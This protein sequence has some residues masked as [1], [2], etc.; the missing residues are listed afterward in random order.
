MKQKTVCLDFN[1]VVHS[2]TTPW[3]DIYTIADGPVEHT[4][5]A[6]KSLRNIGYRVVVFSARSDPDAILD[7]LD[8]HD[9]EVDEVCS[10]KPGASVFV[11]DKAV[12]FRGSWAD[13]IVDIQEFKQ[14]NKA[15]QEPLE[16]NN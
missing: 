11:D 1:G 12:T 10:K 8:K 4:A 7:W 5:W 16:H 13:T 14:W 9:I 2:Y 6:I 3:K 15:N